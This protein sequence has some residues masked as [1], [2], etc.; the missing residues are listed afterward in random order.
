MAEV[1]PKPLSPALSPI[2][3]NRLDRPSGTRPRPFPAQ[4]QNCWL[5]PIL[6]S[7]A[8]TFSTVYSAEPKP[9]WRSQACGNKYRPRA[10]F[11]IAEGHFTCKYSKSF[12]ISFKYLLMKLRTHLNVKSF[13]FY[14]HIHAMNISRTITPQAINSSPELFTFCEEPPSCRLGTV[15]KSIGPVGPRLVDGRAFCLLSSSWLV[16][17]S[18]ARREMIG[19]A[20]S[21]A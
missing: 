14:K 7:G 8:H 19:N 9:S 17:A 1:W 21:R 20:R 3:Q 12:P 10:S 13:Q 18:K 2:G 11:K 4:G 6:P 15:S 16:A 5:S